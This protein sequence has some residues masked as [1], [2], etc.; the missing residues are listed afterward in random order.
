[1]DKTVPRC[2]HVGFFGPHSTPG[3]VPR[4]GPLFWLSFSLFTF[5]WSPVSFQMAVAGNSNRFPSGLACCPCRSTG[6]NNGSDRLWNTT[7][8]S[9]DRYLPTLLLLAWV[10]HQQEPPD[11]TPRCG[12]TR[13]FFFWRVTRPPALPPGCPAASY[14]TRT[15]VAQTLS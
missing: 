11:L 6:S 3:T 4:I 12:L 14:E 15:R 1:M 5:T 9:P 8:R 2:A 10:G 13:R 7:V